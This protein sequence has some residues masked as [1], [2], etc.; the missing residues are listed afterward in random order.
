MTTAPGAETLDTI[1]QPGS[2]APFVLL[3]I[4]QSAM[5][6][7]TTV[8]GLLWIVRVGTTVGEGVLVAEG[9]SGTVVGTAVSVAVAVAVGSGVLVSVLVGTAVAATV[10]AVGG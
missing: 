6:P 9:G 5:R 8:R 4:S 3:G 7:P 2:C 1:S 10:V